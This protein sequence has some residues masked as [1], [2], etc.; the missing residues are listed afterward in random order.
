MQQAVKMVG[1][2]RVRRAEFD[3]VPRNRG[4][5]EMRILR[6]PRGFVRKSV[7]P[8][9]VAYPTPGRRYSFRPERGGGGLLELPQSRSIDFA[10]LTPESRSGQ[11]K[12]STYLYVETKPTRTS[13]SSVSPAGARTPRAAHL[14]N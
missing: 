6:R 4:F 8:D 5:R 12:E 10:L 13:F 14:G 11:G 9:F 1:L 3:S 7:E 2:R